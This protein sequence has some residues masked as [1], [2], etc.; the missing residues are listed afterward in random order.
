[1]GTT[2]NP[3]NCRHCLIF[4]T[5]RTI[6]SVFLSELNTSVTTWTTGRAWIYLQASVIDPIK[7]PLRQWQTDSPTWHQQLGSDEE[8]LPTGKK[9]SVGSSDEQGKHFHVMVV[10]SDPKGIASDS[11][12]QGKR[13]DKTLT[14]EEETQWS[15]T[16]RSF[17]GLQTV[18]QHVYCC[19][20]DSYF[21]QI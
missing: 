11:D 2:G 14:H 21:E 8:Q 3:P 15:I 16:S 4:K 20:Y 18:N 12:R 10:Q 1:M 7:G 9:I 17:W 5:H 13:S 19:T 6:K